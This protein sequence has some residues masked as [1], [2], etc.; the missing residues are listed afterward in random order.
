MNNNDNTEIANKTVGYAVGL[1]SGVIAIG[2]AILSIMLAT[3]YY[4]R[5]VQREEFFVTIV[6]M[7]VSFVI[8]FG[9]IS[10]RV[11]VSQITNQKELMS[12]NGWRMLAI[13]FIIFGIVS[14]ILGHWLALLLPSA[15]AL[16]CLWK[17]RRV[18]EMIR[19]IHLIP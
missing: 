14:A 10:F 7:C 15:I 19:T 5:G 6:S 4:D 11:F 9:V 16:F 17:D 18:I 13:I 8:F 12:L 1:I 2:L 3:K